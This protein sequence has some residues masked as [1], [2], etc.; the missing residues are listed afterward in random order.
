MLVGYQH[1]HFGQFPAVVSQTHGQGRITT[2]GTV[3]DAAFGA[4]LAR[5]LAPDARWAGLPD[6]VTVHSATNRDGRRVHVVHNWSWEPAE[7]VLPQ[8]LTD[9]LSEEAPPL[10]TGSTSAPGTSA[11]SPIRRERP[12]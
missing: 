8:P 1:P 9:L 10:E 4:D 2:V 5:W 3:P 6:S 7:I 11:C 12:R